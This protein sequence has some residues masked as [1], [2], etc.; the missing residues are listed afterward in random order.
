[1]LLE[2]S[3][4][5]VDLI[6]HVYDAEIESVSSEIFNPTESMYRGDATVTAIFDMERGIRATYLGSWV[7]G[8]NLRAFEWRTDCRDGAL[9]Q[10]ALF[11]DLLAGARTGP[12]VPVP[13]ADVEPFV[14]DTRAYAEAAF[15]AL[16]AGAPVPCS[17]AD[18]LRSLAATIACRVSAAE[19]RAVRPSDLIAAAESPTS[20]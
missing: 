19:G 5:H 10:R 18:H 15:E 8:T 4:H 7:T 13:V 16:A 12:L 2:Q 11:G 6:R 1:M 17:G 20:A 14:T 9:L 3:I